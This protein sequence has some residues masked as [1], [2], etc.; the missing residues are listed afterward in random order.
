VL[1]VG[2]RAFRNFREN[3]KA[4]KSLSKMNFVKCQHENTFSDAEMAEVVRKLH[5]PKIVLPVI[6]GFSDL[7]YF[8]TGF[9]I[10]DF[11]TELLRS[12]IDSDAA[13]RRDHWSPSVQQIEMLIIVIRQ[14]FIGHSTLDGG[15]HRF[16]HF[17]RLDTSSI[18]KIE[19]FSMCLNFDF[20][21]EFVSADRS[22]KGCAA[23]AASFDIEFIENRR[24]TSFRS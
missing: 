16:R 14:L 1:R 18:F 5:P 13:K 11:A 22:E 15:T 3:F 17:I 20:V 9:R 2:R 4:R 21:R 24:P 23:S 8:R 12:L 7:S 6:N 10:Y 19:L